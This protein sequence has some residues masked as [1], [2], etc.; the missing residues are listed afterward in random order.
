M[1]YVLYIICLT[2]MTDEIQWASL[3]LTWKQ[4]KHIILVFID[5]LLL[6]IYWDYITVS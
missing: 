2:H 6:N 5:Y 3:L 1:F 4:A